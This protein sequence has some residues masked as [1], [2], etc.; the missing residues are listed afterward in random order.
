M[1]QIL[2][3]TLQTLYFCAT[4]TEK[5]DENH[6]NPARFRHKKK[7]LQHKRTLTARR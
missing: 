5:Y 7:I 4:H 3:F 2:Y 6:P 1:L